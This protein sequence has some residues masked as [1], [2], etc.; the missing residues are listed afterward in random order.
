[1]NLQIP[2]ASLLYKTCI[3]TEA[4]FRLYS[5][6]EDVHTVHLSF[7][8]HF[9]LVLCN[10]INEFRTQTKCPVRHVPYNIQLVCIFL[11]S[12]EEGKS[13]QSYFY[14]KIMFIVSLCSWYF[15]SNI[16]FIHSQEN[17]KKI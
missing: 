6:Y 11:Q 12:L 15:F 9:T 10:K 16:A 5:Y 2:N 13:K 8:N 1:M 3:L 17:N 7:K 4:I 14:P